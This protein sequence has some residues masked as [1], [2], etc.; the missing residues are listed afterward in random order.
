MPIIAAGG[1]Y[2]GR[3]LASALCYGAS[4]VWIGTRFMMSP[5]ANTSQGYKERLLKASSD[6]TIVTKAYT[7]S[8]MRVIKNP[9]V[10]KFQE[11]P[12]LLEES[13]ALVARRAWND[14]VWKLHSGAGV[15]DPN[16]FDENNQAIV[17]G[18][19]IGAIKEVKPCKDIVMEINDTC[20]DVLKNLSSQVAIRSS[21]L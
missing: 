17:T 20:W 7:G 5:E 18:Q 3:G 16:E 12:N 6:D 10:L 15:G 21:K 13:S 4:G 2:D 1:I 11:N 8:T 14:G 9:Y 19:C